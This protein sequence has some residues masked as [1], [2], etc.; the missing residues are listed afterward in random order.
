MKA[1]ERIRRQWEEKKLLMQVLASDGEP[2]EVVKIEY[3][4]IQAS[5]ALMKT[6]SLMPAKKN[7]RRRFLGDMIEDLAEGAINDLRG[8]GY[9]M[10]PV[11]L[12]LSKV[13]S[14][15]YEYTF[16]Y[17]KSKGTGKNKR[18]HTDEYT[19]TGFGEDDAIHTLKS[20]VK[21]L[22]ETLIEVKKTTRR[23]SI[24]LLTDGT[25]VRAE[26]VVEVVGK[27]VLK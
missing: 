23:H 15:I 3:D 18:I 22:G 9:V 5:M 8:L 24:Y 21:R 26:D 17:S 25:R 1:Q 2:M 27:E 12:D 14:I 16:T 6:Y 19:C 10:N 4:F 13:K 11:V 7:G 20:R